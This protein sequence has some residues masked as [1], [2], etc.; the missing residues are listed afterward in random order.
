[1]KKTILPLVIATLSIFSTVAQNLLNGDFE[2]WSTT[3]ISYNPNGLG[4]F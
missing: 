4:E 1:M 3:G 2:N